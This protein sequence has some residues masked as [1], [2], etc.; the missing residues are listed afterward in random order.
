MNQIKT[1]LV[2]LL[3]SSLSFAQVLTPRHWSFRAQHVKGD[4]YDL[5]LTMDI[6]KPWHGY[7]QKVDGDAP[8]P[9]SIEFDKN[10]DVELIGATAEGGPNVHV[11]DDVLNGG[12]MKIFEDRAIFTQRIKLKKATIV[13]GA[14]TAQVC[15]D[16]S[17]LPPETKIFKISVGGATTGAD[18]AKAKSGVSS[19]FGN[20][21]QNNNAGND[22]AAASTD[23]A[24]QTAAASTSGLSGYYQNFFDKSKFEKAVI[25]EKKQEFTVWIII[26]LGLGGGLGALLTP[27]VFPMIPLTVSFFIKR[28]ENKTKGRWE[29]VFYG[30]SITLIFFLLSLPFLFLN[31]SGNALNEL[32]TNMWYNL[33]FFIVFIIFAVSFFGYYEIALPSSLATKV[34]SASNAG[35]MIGIFFMALTLVIVSFSCTGPLI[36]TLLASLNGANGKMNLMIGM[37]TF[38]FAM[39]LPFTVFAF[40]PDLLKKLPKSGG[41]MD[42]VKKVFGFAELILALKFLSNADLQAHWGVLKRE[43][44]LGIWVILGA[45]LF[46]YLI[47]VLRF[48]SEAPVKKIAPIRMG[49]AA[50]VLL[51]T[52]YCAYGLSGNDLKLLSGFIPPNYYS[53]YAKPSD[54]PD[55]LSCF[56]DYDEGLA[57]ARQVNKP[58]FI[59]FTGYNCANCRKMEESIWTDPEV[60]HRLREKYVVISLYVDDY[61]RKLPADM[62]YKSPMTGDDRTSYGDKWSDFQAI[63]FNT[64]TQPQYA[65]ISPQEQRLNTPWNGYDADPKK[66]KDF[67]DEGLDAFATVKAK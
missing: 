65:L 26:L 11:I 13:T 10:T 39:G 16:K 49:V 41:W 24:S 64:N 46:L 6:D 52:V 20:T 31:L 1:L 22:Q 54:C 27:C 15:N 34:D 62:V 58:V 47:G 32:S 28:G 50:L 43:I 33:I 5:I 21:S 9:T 61:R 8:L 4:Q 23:T 42:T 36:G 7:S 67:L 30:F 17:C 57:Y 2:L 12:K 59:D 66:F 48:K 56:H 14:V 19:A 44:F 55:E 53:I 37:T 3:F 51:F 38:G 29:S 45:A 40:F 60:Y 25:A 18:T 63:C 35:G